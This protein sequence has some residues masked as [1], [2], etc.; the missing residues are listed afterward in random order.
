MPHHESN[1]GT[2]TLVSEAVVTKS[3]KVQ[4]TKCHK[5]EPKK[6]KKK[7]KGGEM[8]EKR[9]KEVQAGLIAAHTLRTHRVGLH[10]PRDP[11]VSHWHES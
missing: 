1:C 7:K 11:G 10:F 4:E 8:Q 6:K 3:G 5:I 2:I 9:R